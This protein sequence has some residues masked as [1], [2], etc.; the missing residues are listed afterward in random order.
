M[1]LMSCS[2]CIVDHVG[3]YTLGTSN[4]T[5]PSPLGSYTHDQA[6]PVALSP[7]PQLPEKLHRLMPRENRRRSM[8]GPGLV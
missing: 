6:A 2:R 1:R 8:L 3:R 4:D 5:P 7:T